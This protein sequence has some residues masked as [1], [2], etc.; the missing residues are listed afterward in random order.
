MKEGGVKRARRSA[1]VPSQSTVD[2]RPIVPATFLG[3]KGLAPK[4]L[5]EVFLHS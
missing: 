2:F 5:A 1:W 3:V 4:L